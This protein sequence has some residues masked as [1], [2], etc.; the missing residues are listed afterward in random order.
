[1]SEQV[2]KKEGLIGTDNHMHGIYALS[3]I[4]LIGLVIV[5]AVA[6]GVFSVAQVTNTENAVYSIMQ[7]SFTH[8]AASFSQV[9][10][11]MNATIDRNQ[12]IADIIGW[13]V[14]IALVFVAFTPVQALASMHRR[15]N[16]I[17]TVSLAKH[18]DFLGK[19][20]KIMQWTL[21][22]GDVITDFWYVAQGQALIA[23]DGWHPSFPNPGLLVIAIVFPVGI[24][25]VTIFVGKFLFV[26]LDALINKA[27][28]FK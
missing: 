23:W 22:I 5:C 28:A 20:C 1:M 8:N 3:P 13:S 11:L 27:K 21:I 14:Q 4:E 15:H 24:C 2:A 25:F 18:A 12:R 26:F 17:V 16:S 9:A 6:F 19:L 7:V 10:S